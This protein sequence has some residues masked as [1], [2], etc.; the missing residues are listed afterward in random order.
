M[1][2]ILLTGADVPSGVSSDEG[3]WFIYGTGIVFDW[4]VKALWRS[5]GWGEAG[6]GASTGGPPRRRSPPPGYFQ[7]DE[8]AGNG[9][10]AHRNVARR[11]RYRYRRPVPIHRRWTSWVFFVRSF[12]LSSW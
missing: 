3:C 9:A 12:S 1:L 4:S 5:Q 6:Q 10:A 7:T 11:R 8:G 2:A